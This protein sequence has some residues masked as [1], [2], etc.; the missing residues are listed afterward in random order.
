MVPIDHGVLFPWIPYMEPPFR[1]NPSHLFPNGFSGI[2][3]AITLS[4]FE[5]YQEGLIIFETIVN[6]PSGV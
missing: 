2:P 6:L 3:P 4:V 1:D 5:L